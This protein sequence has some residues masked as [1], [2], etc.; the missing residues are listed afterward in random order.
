MTQVPK[1]FS[2]SR[3]I[4]YLSLFKRDTEM[5][6]S[7]AQDYS[8]AIG[9]PVGDVLVTL[10]FTN[11]EE[12]YKKFVESIQTSTSFD[13]KYIASVVEVN[14]KINTDLI[15]VI[16]ECYKADGIH[17]YLEP[18]NDLDL[19]NLHIDFKSRV[20]ADPIDLEL[21][22]NSNY[23]DVQVQGKKYKG[24]FAINIKQGQIVN[25][26]IK[27]FNNAAI[28]FSLN[29]VF[30]QRLL[31]NI[32]TTNWPKPDDDRVSNIATGT[33]TIYSIAKKTTPLPP[34]DILKEV[35]LEGAK[36][37]LPQAT[38]T[39]QS[40]DDQELKGPRGT[41]LNNG[42]FTL[43][44]QDDKVSATLYATIEEPRN[45]GTHYIV[46][47]QYD[48]YQAPYGYK[49]IGIEPAD[50]TGNA[51]AFSDIQGDFGGQTLVCGRGPIDKIFWIGDTGSAQDYLEGVRINPF[52]KNLIVHLIK[53]K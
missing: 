8:A 1:N 26:S 13:S 44:F 28:L 29:Q 18:T 16:L 6:Y 45:G 47:K 9:I 14:K 10:G 20:S 46:S 7:Q 27:R 31:P 41:A 3:A 42:S 52:L 12:S 49:I 2:S 38:M 15:D 30:K 35:K 50:G 22:W 34:I 37:T 32:A 43:N 53:N 51:T 48:I 17:A 33:L 4:S 5:T 21:K 24:T 40:G 11:S 19:Y 36:I 25:L 39:A 23:G